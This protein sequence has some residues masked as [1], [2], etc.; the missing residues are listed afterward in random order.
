MPRVWD[1]AGAVILDES[2]LPEPLTEFFE[3]LRA[4]RIAEAIAHKPRTA[5]QPLGQTSIDLGL[6]LEEDGWSAQS[7]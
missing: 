7:P 6:P 5:R 1:A 4:L 2:R 3:R